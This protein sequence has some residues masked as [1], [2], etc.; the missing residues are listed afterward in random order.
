[1]SPKKQSTDH[2]SKTAPISSPSLAGPHALTSSH[3]RPVVLLRRPQV[4]TKLGIARAT[5]YQWLDPGSPQ[6]LSDMPR[7]IKLSERSRCCYWV[8]AEVDLF[9][10]QRVAQARQFH[11]E[12]AQ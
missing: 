9:I 7:P 10:E 8:E 6:H 2:P 12:G 3:Q 1:M 11:G 4:L 5:L